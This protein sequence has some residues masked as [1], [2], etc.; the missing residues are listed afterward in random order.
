M[1]QIAQFFEEQ[2]GPVAKLTVQRD[3]RRLVVAGQRLRASKLAAER[4]VNMLLQACKTAASDRQ[5]AALQVR[6]EGAVAQVREWQGQMEGE[7]ARP[8]P[9]AAVFVT[10]KCAPLCRACLRCT[11]AGCPKFAE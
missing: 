6:L 4:L 5:L 2:A 1:A 9:I 3:C 10:F 7:R 11:A 8:R